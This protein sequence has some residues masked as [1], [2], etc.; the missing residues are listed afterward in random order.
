MMTGVLIVE[1]PPWGKDAVKEFTPE[2]RAT[3][4]TVD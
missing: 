1:L 2:E 4:G 3:L